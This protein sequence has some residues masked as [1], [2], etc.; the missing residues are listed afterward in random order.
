M[1]G[2]YVQARSV[3][4]LID[5]Y[6]AVDA[7]DGE[8]VEPSWNVAPTR[9]EP[10]LIRRAER[11]L[12]VLQWGLVPSWAKDPSVGSRLI[13]ARAESVAE[14]PAF[15]TALV[16]RRCLVPADGWYE[17]MPLDP[18]PDGKQRKQPF[19]FHRGDGEPLAFAGLFEHWK[20]RDDADAAWLSTYTVITTTATDEKG[21]VHDRAPVLIE[22]AD[23]DRWLDRELTEAP[24][25][26]LRPSAPG[27]I[28]GRPV[29]TLVSN[30]H[31][32][33]PELLAE[34]PLEEGT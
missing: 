8:E 3:Q 16:K 19:W 31:N 25:E 24:V 33:G 18:G 5:V 23:W 10:V 9:R 7:T 6:G 34:L 4:D 27:L 32:D 1:C 29:P 2:R 17:W 15:R 22:P 21:R 11:Q 14:K 20:P 28:V 26:L 30:V 12:R 13:N